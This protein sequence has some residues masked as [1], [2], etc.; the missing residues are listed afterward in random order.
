[1][2]G[3]I[4]CWNLQHYEKIFKLGFG[5]ELFL[6]TGLLDFYSKVGDLSST[7]KLF[8]DMPER[9]VVACN[10]MISALGM[11]GYVKKGRESFDRM[12]EKTSSSWNTMISCY[13]KLGDV[14]SARMIFDSNPVKNVISLNAMID[15]YCKL[16]QFTIARELFDRMGLLKNTMTWNTMISG[17]VQHREFGRAISIFQDMQAENAKPTGETMVSLLSA[18]AH[19][20]ALD[21]G[22]WIH[23]YIRRQ[24]LKVDVYLGNALV[25]N[26][27]PDIE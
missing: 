19:L 10:A 22:Y 6:Q 3:T 9:D 7:K 25:D 5:Y 15:G 4:C 24:K 20:G 26:A 21:M 27:S 16:N 17:Y 2:I 18:C 13:C 14:E 1:M 11:H 23:G 8:D 12:R